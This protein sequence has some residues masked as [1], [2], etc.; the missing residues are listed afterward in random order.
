MEVS[1][2]F[3]EIMNKA[4][5][6]S[7]LKVRKVRLGNKTVK[8]EPLTPYQTL[9]SFQKLQA[10]I[11][12][13]LE[14]L[15]KGELTKERFIRILCATLEEAWNEVIDVVSEITGLDKEYLL[16]KTTTKQVINFII[17]L[18]EVNT[19]EEVGDVSKK[20]IQPVLDLLKRTG[21]T[22]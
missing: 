22:I 1:D 6:A 9:T 4:K 12:A 19:E 3:K 10:V 18:F 8:V 14:V 2:M 11:P 13:F 15:L 21:F 17:V 20:G 7:Q 5:D 16:H